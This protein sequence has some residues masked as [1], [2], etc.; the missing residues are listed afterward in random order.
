MKAQF[1]GP[2]N[3]YAKLRVTAES[4]GEWAKLKAV[5]PCLQSYQVSVEILESDE[6]RNRIATLDPKWV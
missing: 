1:L 3:P 2:R 5:F 4:P 6:A